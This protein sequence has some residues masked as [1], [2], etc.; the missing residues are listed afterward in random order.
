MKTLHIE[1]TETSFFLPAADLMAAWQ[2][3]SSEETR[4][5]L[6]GVFLE[7]DGTACRAVATDGHMA[8]VIEMPAG[9][10]I[11]AGACTQSANEYSGFIL[12]VDVAEKAFKA[13]AYGDLW[14][15]GDTDTGILQFV[16]TAAKEDSDPLRRVGVCEFH[17]IG[18]TFP[19]WRHIMPKPGTA[20]VNAC[21]NPDLLIRFKKSFDI[22][23]KER[24][25]KAGQAIHLACGDN[26]GDPIEVTGA[27]CARAKGV[28]MPM[29]KY[30]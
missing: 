19:D 1:K 18:G 9:A 5:Y 2:S 6:Q 28:L 11:G 12:S 23:G 8:L 7:T 29:R 22:L 3:T 15:Y 24:G 30:F 13:K 17:R 21:F 16:D 26:E 10:F 25:L 27:A 14:V 4:Y 20:R